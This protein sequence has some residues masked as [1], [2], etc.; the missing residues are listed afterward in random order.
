MSVCDK[1]VLSLGEKTR[2]VPCPWVIKDTHGMLALQSAL[3]QRA[4]SGVW[5]SS[6]YPVCFILRP[7]KGCGILHTI[8]DTG[9]QEIKE[10]TPNYR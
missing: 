7:P 3:C 10:N 8:Q 6:E 9:N 4:G 2:E 5:G 1:P